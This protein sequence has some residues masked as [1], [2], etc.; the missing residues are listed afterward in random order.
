M[1]TWSELRIDKRLQHNQWKLFEKKKKETF[2]VKYTFWLTDVTDESTRFEFLKKL[3]YSWP[4]FTLRSLLSALLVY[5]VDVG[6]L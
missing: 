2:Y 3:I 5:F 1:N 4:V 6:L